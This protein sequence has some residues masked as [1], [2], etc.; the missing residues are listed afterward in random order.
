MIINASYT[1]QSQ[2]VSSYSEPTREESEKED[3]C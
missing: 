3:M 2:M 1:K